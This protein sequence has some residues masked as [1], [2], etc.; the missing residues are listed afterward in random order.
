MCKN[1]KIK[2]TF[3]IKRIITEDAINDFAKVSGDSNPVHL[4]ESYAKNSIFEKKI[5]HGFLVASSISTVIGMHL[6]GNGTIYLSQNLKFRKPVFIG[7]EI[8]TTVEVLD[9]PKE[10]RVLLKTTCVNQLGE[11][12]IEGEAIVIP[13]QGIEIIND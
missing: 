5:A 9:F 10:K 2:D 12:V 1:L 11:S 3:S 8:T 7:D 13:P 4:D 6:P